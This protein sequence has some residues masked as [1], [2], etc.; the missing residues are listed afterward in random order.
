MKAFGL[1]ARAT[2]CSLL[3]APAI[4][5]AAE[6]TGGKNLG[7]LYNRIAADLASGRP[8]V[9]TIFVALCDNDTQGIVKVK[10]RRICLGDDP[11]HNLYWA[12]AG[13]L[14]AVLRSAGWQRVSIDYFAQGDLAVKAIWR[15]RLAPGGAL[16]ARA[17]LSRFDAYIVGLGYRG[18]E[19]R[20]AMTDY[21]QAVNRDDERLESAADVRLSAGGASQLVGYI[22]HDYF[23]DVVDP[24]PLLSLRA[25]NSLLHKGTFALSCTGH[26]LIRPA[27]RRSN[28]H[29]LML[30]RSLGFPGAWTAEAIVTAIADG[31]D[32][33]AIHRYAATAFARGQ[34]IPLP[35][36]LGAFA[37][38]D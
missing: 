12:T 16:R 7:H 30:N 6:E 14:A 19:I 9:A 25:G 26:R 31:Q 38:G 37:Y 32:A 4:A 20:K 15:K 24:R 22:G 35:S 5:S 27:I 8:L 17:I 23:Y 21:L 29:I 36:A 10:N 33:R 1:F 34:R 3:F 13:G 11:D 2:I 28:A 18:S